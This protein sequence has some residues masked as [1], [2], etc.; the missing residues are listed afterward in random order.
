MKKLIVLASLLLAAAAITA[1][2]LWPMKLS[3]AFE[4]GEPAYFI[5]MAPLIPGSGEPAD[6]ELFRV[7][8]GSPEFESVV[9]ILD[10]YRYHRSLRTIFGGEDKADF[11]C[12][13]WLYIRDENLSSI[14]TFLGTGEVLIGDGVYSLYCSDGE[15]IAITEAIYEAVKGG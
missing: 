6:P 10:G 11:L 1:F 5:F 13:W 14:L 4:R 8:R 2:F 7:S 12:P 3:D 9:E 15:A